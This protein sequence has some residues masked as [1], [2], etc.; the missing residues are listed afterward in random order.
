MSDQDKKPP[1]TDLE[2][3]KPP[4]DFVPIESASPLFD[5]A[6]FEQIQR[7]AR[8]VC[9]STL[10]PE[11]IR[12]TPEQTFSNLVLIF[13]KAKRWD[14]DG[15]EVAQCSSIVHGKLV[16]EGKLVAA[17]LESRGIR[18]E[19]E[20]IGK[21]SDGDAYAIIVSGRPRGKNDPLT[22][23]GT[24]GDWKTLEKNGNIKANWKGAN[25]KRQQAAGT[26]AKP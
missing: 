19:Y 7:A 2:P 18:L 1:G 13:A 23:E 9:H 6:T 5:T 12:G 15:M 25:A 3:V 20:W 26:S 24:V 21:P 8:A 22:I 16:Y 4:R 11:S 10:L 17:V 14:M